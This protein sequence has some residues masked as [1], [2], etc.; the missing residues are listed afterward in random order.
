MKC[1]N[2]FCNAECL[3]FRSGSL[4]WIDKPMGRERVLTGQ[5]ASSLRRLVWL[6]SACSQNCEVQ[7]WRPAGEQIRERKDGEY[8]RNV[9]RYRSLDRRT[10]SRSVVLPHAEAS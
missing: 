8:A 9:I 4:H 5:P 10:V 3:Y 2:L 1:E 7:S 6:C